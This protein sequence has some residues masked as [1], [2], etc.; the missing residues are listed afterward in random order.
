M[1]KAP[2][3]TIPIT[4]EGFVK[5]KKEHE[6]LKKVQ[7]PNIIKKVAEARANGDLKENAE[8][9]AAREHQSYLQSRIEFVEDKIARSQIIK[10]D[11]ANSETVIFGH[12]VKTLDIEDDTEEEFTLVGEAEAEPMNGKIST[13]SPIGKSLI[14]KKIGDIVEIETPGGILNLKILDF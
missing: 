5:L 9:H 14:G 13:A 12:C 8:Y 3:D 4:Q 10:L 6:N 1:E 11:T 2:M 7:L